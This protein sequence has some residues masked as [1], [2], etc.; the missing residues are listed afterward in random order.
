MSY[1]TNQIAIPVFSVG[2]AELVTL[3]IC[4][5]K[6]NY[7]NTN[8]DSAIKTFKH[9]V[10]IARKEYNGNYFKVFY[11]A[12]IPAVSAQVFSTTSK[13][14]LYR[15]FDEYSPYKIANGAAAGFLVSLITHPIDRIK[16]HLQMI[17]TQTIPNNS[18]IW[19]N[20]YKG[21]SKTF[22]KTIIGGM[23][24][25]PLYD[26]I[27]SYNL[28][29]LQSSFISAVV[30]TC[31]LHPFDYMKT[32]HCY[33]LPWFAGY[34]PLSYMRGLHINLMRIVPHFVITM[35]LIEKLREFENHKNQKIE[36][37]TINK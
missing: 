33:N 4:T 8:S 15:K 22:T 6:S 34:N 36:I 7:Q 30:S 14:A 16:I 11:K 21:Y 26:Y 3:P 25:F 13:L 37:K 32:R 10:D 31:A 9:M 27:K 23:M 17:S 24:Y 12:S 2:V 18:H 5:L 20:I 28:T 19:A 35:T 1:F 29:P